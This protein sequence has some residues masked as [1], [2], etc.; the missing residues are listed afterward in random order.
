MFSVLAQNV[1]DYLE[2]VG[3]F[4]AAA[5]VAL[6]RVELIYYKPQEVYHAMRILAGQIEDGDNGGESGEEPKFEESRG[7]APFIVVPELVRRKLLFQ[8]IAGP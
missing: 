4:K 3:N 8:R 1:Q 7:P 2:R 5:E 6:R